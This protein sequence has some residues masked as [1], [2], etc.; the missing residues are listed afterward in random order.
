MEADPDADGHLHLMPTDRD[1]RDLAQDLFRDQLGILSTTQRFKD[2]HELVA[3]DPGHGVAATDGAHERVSDG[4]QHQIA[5]LMAVRIV[6]RLEV[7]DIE[8]EHGEDRSGSD[9]MRQRLAEAIDQQVAVGQVGELIV[10]GHVLKVELG[11]L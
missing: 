6:H 9:G 4:L 10:R 1:G 3:A 11:P 8:E 2:D 7:V 5:E